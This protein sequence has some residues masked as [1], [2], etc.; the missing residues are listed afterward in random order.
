VSEPFVKREVILARDP[1][2]RRVFW[3][4]H[5]V[6]G[7]AQELRPESEIVA[8]VVEQRGTHRRQ[9][10]TFRLR[11]HTDWRM[12]DGLEWSWNVA[13][14]SPTSSQP[15]T[16]HTQGRTLRFQKPD[17]VSYEIVTSKTLPRDWTRV[18]AR[19]LH[20]ATMTETEALQK[21]P[22]RTTVEAR[23]WHPRIMGG[24]G[25][26]RIAELNIRS[27][28]LS[29]ILGKTA[30]QPVQWSI[31]SL[32]RWVGEEK[33]GQWSFVFK[34]GR[35]RIEGELLTPFKDMWT[36]R[37]QDSDGVPYFVSEHFFGS[38]ELRLYEQ[39]ALRAHWKCFEQAHFETGNPDRLSIHEDIR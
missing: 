13:A 17:D 12:L 37:T 20:P 18:I 24:L 8:A 9:L 33:P 26:P 19:N 39:G 29:K 4:H 28:E 32:E 6:R 14:D 15:W 3:L 7:N 22:M 38:L 11:S 21:E 30:A 1:E 10:E 31:R 35:F 23:L 34:K 5:L 2:N 27:E 36:F 16:V 25:F